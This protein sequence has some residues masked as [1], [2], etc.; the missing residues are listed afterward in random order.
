MSCNRITR[1]HAS[2]DCAT[3]GMCERHCTCKT[4]EPPVDISEGAVERMAA[5]FGYC[6][7]SDILRTLRAA[8]SKAEAKY[9]ALEKRFGEHMEAWRVNAAAREAANEKLRGLLRE[10]IDNRAMPDWLERARNA[11]KE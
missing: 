9:A 8:L 10:V 2:S 7:A 3:C 6:D 5:A 1:N 4:N 11:V